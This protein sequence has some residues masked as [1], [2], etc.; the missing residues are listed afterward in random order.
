MSANSEPTAQRIALQGR[1]EL[2]A[3]LRAAILRQAGSAAEPLTLEAAQLDQ[4]VDAA[5]ARA[6]GV[7]WRRCLAGA[8]TN[9]LGVGLADAVWHP[10]VQRASELAG[11]PRY[12]RDEPIAPVP[13]AAPAS[14]SRV[15]SA[16]AQAQA[17]AEAQPPVQAL[18]LPAVH[19]SGI[20]SLRNG[21]S[22]LELRFSDAGLDLL[23][24]SSG[25]AIGRLVWSEIHSID[26]AGPRRVLRPG[27]RTQELH[28]RAQSGRATFQL[29]GMTS[30]QLS[31][32][33]EPA[34]ARLRDG[35]GRS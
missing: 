35:G 6:G 3:R 19:V 24:A 10:T 29:P 28:V 23:K 9:E 33:L 25:A 12:E 5:A 11:A 4:L 20:E 16:A 14:A 22:D 13:R 17:E 26:V 2:H 30:E 31:S 1:Q 21:E 8:A 32:H 27:R 34:L 18:R 7:L 15:A